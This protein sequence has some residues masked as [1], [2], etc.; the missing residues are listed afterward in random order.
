VNAHAGRYRLVDSLRGIAALMVL[1]THVTWFSGT[2]PGDAPLWPYLSRLESGVAVFFVIS[3]FL[4]YRP[5]V[6]ARLLDRRPLPVHAYA[7][8]RLLRITPAFWVALTVIGI[9]LGVDGLWS[10]REIAIN[11]GFLQLYRGPSPLNVIPQG[12]S[13]CVEI[14]FY[15]L[16]PLWAWLMRRLP[17]RDF[18]ARLRWE[19][20]MVGGLVVASVAYNAALVYSGAAG[21]IT[22]LAPVTLLAALPGFLDTLGVGML[23]AVVSVWIEHG[24]EGRLPAPLAFLSRHP[25]LCLAIAA[26]ALWAPA[27][28]IVLTGPAV[29]YSGSQYMERHLLNALVGA[30]LLVPAVFGDSRQGFTRRVL[31]HPALLY[32]GVISYSVYLYHLAVITQLR[33]WGLSSVPLAYLTALAGAVALASVSYYLVERPALSLKRLVGSVPE[34]TPVKA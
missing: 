33:D 27:S 9:W 15:A 5:F 31:G 17:G 13:M 22:G 30:A 18:N 21:D 4:L 7:W 12:W 26:L 14:A 1:I 11:Y 2:V 32:L 6:K 8:R 20:W 3:G 19:L 23:L 24:R 28:H 34:P 10:G 25:A 29:V 16:L